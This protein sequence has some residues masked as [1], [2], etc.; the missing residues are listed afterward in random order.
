MTHATNGARYSVPINSRRIEG[1]QS[2]FIL[3]T[4]L[5]KHGSIGNGFKFQE[6]QS[7]NDLDCV[8]TPYYDAK[9]RNFK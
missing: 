3:A 8:S 9:P 4:P 5:K 6:L 2:D 1:N 7:Q